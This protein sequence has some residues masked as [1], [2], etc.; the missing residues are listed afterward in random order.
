ML[1][2]YEREKYACIYLSEAL[3]TVRLNAADAT[4]DSYAPVTS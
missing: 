4:K 3:S 1:I 2:E